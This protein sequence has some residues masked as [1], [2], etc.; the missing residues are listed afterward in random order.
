M[1]SYIIKK[2]GNWISLDENKSVSTTELLFGY[3][4]VTYN[5][6]KLSFTKKV[7]L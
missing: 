3:K 4:A 6:T 7:A 1:T 2:L 5:G